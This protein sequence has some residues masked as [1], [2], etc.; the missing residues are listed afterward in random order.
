MNSFQITGQDDQ[1]LSIF[2]LLLHITR[3]YFNTEMLPSLILAFYYLLIPPPL[4]LQGAFQPLK[5]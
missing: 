1:G 3:D 5:P 4:I 2:C